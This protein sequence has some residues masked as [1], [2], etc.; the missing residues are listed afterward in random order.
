MVDF[1]KN[2][3][4]YRGQYLRKRGLYPPSKRMLSFLKKKEANKEGSGDI[5]LGQDESAESELGEEFEDEEE[6]EESLEEGA[7]EKQ[8][9][10]SF[11]YLEYSTKI[12]HLFNTFEL[13]CEATSE[14]ENS[15]KLKNCEQICNNRGKKRPAKKGK[16][17]SKKSRK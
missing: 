6:E 1:V 8:P 13:T 15:K 5:E 3:F 14:R 2:K 4:K 10:N 9:R 11:N 12:K 17:K 7:K 16:K